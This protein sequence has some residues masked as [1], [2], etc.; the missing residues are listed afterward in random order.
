[1]PFPFFTKNEVQERWSEYVP[2][3]EHLVY[4]DGY[5]CKWKKLQLVS[6]EERKTMKEL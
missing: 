4:I 5:T 3:E 1:M 2:D 6:E